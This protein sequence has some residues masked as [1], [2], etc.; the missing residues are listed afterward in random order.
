MAE[1]FVD[2]NQ[3][4]SAKRFVIPLFLEERQG[5][6]CGDHVLVRG[7]DVAPREAKVL[8]LRDSGRNAELEFC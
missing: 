7:D 2:Y 4:G 1:V 3:I 8:A 5:L 6:R